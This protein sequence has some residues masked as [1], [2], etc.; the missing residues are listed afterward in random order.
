M[1]RTSETDQK[2]HVTTTSSAY[3]MGVTEVFLTKYVFKGM[4]SQSEPTEVL[5]K[6]QLL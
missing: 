5:G 2:A 3:K 4:V 1:E 6:S